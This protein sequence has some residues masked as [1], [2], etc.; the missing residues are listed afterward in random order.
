M[1]FIMNLVIK[2]MQIKKTSVFHPYLF[3]IF[4]IIST[5]S[6]NMQE[7]LPIYLIQPVII[8]TIFTTIIFLITKLIFKNWSKTGVFVSLIIGLV[9]SYGHVYLQISG[10]ELSG[11]EI[12]RHVFLIIPYI[13]TFLIVGIYVFKT[14]L[15][16]ENITK[17]LNVVAM[18]LILVSVVSIGIYAIENEG[19]GI[20][21][22][23]KEVIDQKSG[24]EIDV[25]N[26]KMI[27]LVGDL[28]KY[29][30]VYYILFDGYAGESSLEKD[31]G[32]DNSNFIKLL[33]QKGFFV[34]SNSYSNYPQTFLSVPSTMNMQYLNYL[35]DVLGEES[36]DQIT[37][38]M[39]MEN[40]LVSEIFKSKGYKIVTF[41]NNSFDNINADYL[42]CK[43]TSFF[44]GNK[45]M[46]I[47][48]KINIFQYFLEWIELENLRNNQ[49]CYFT[50]LPNL[51]NQ[52]EE[53]VFVF[54]HILL[55]HPPNVFGP[56]GEHVMPRIYY[57]E[58]GTQEDKDRYLDTLQ[59]ANLRIEEIV[60]KILKDNERDSIIIISS[61]HGTDFDFDW[62]DPTNEMLKQRFSNLNAYY[63]PKGQELL[64]ENITPVNSFRIIFNSNFN[65]NFELLEDKAY[66]STYDKPYNFKD[67]TE[68]VNQKNEE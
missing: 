16:F 48:I 36:K 8:I 37:P 4:P 56:N 51:K 57:N 7:L 43:N 55:P 30:D 68:V 2:L 58:W 63:M 14:K 29:P 3:A 26:E 12:G 60:N 19:L 45:L 6:A 39:M 13:V 15:K 65:G 41:L 1:L 42:A 54:A 21:V 46:S 67:V 52:F 5:Y 11:F 9:F 20:I 53:P 50:E 27:A 25:Q 31:F 47:I 59:Y 24:I 35:K 49:E 32:F 28:Q 10:F 22:L 61:D 18:T 64:Y 62:N 34:A 33:E 66:W 38:M 44:E 40:S 17:I 23:G